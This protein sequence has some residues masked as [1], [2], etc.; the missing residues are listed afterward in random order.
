MVQESWACGIGIPL[1]SRAAERKSPSKL[2]REPPVTEVT[3]DGFFRKQG[4][5][6][7]RCRFTPEFQVGGEAF[8]F[9]PKKS[10]GDKNHG[11]KQ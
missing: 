6:V 2:R 9:T 4:G 7:E 3:S 1:L 10:E 8:F 5:T 11:R